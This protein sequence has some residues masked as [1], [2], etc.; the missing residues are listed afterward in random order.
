MANKTIGQLTEATSV[1]TTDLFLLEQTGTAK[2]LTGQTL[3]DQLAAALDGHGGIESIA[4][5][6]TSGLVDTYTITMTDGATFAFRV[7]NG[8]DGT[9]GTN[10]R[11]GTN[12]VSPTIAVSNITGGHRLTITDA[13]G[14]RTVNVMD[15]TNGTNGTN[16]TDG[17]DGTNGTNGTDGKDGTT[18]FP[19][20]SAEGVISW[21][22]DGGKSNP[23]SV[24][25]HGEDG[26]DGVDGVTFTPS[27]SAEGVISWTNDGGRVN[28]LSVNIK[29]AQGEQGDNWFV[30]IKWASVQPTSDAD[31]GDIPDAWMGVYGG[32]SATAPTHYT[33]YAWYE[34]KGAKGDNGDPITAIT[35]TSGDGSPGTDDTYTVYVNSTAVGTFIV[36]NGT[37]GIGT[38]NSINGIGVTS[39]TNNVVL[40]A[41]DVGAAAVPLHLQATVTSLPYTIS[42]REITSAM[43]VI[44]CTFGTPSAISSNVTWTTS[45]GSIVLSGT[46]S[47]S[48]TVDL[49][50]I[51][52]T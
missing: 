33:D 25:I 1:Q 6:S 13:N 2:K 17:K 35:R 14:T 30:Y 39:G 3:V 43:S 38:V 45:D 40:T 41:A 16:G 37:D 10:G 36:H 4:K 34:V 15:G 49:V 46:M 51:E 32:A 26:T 28:P 42:N 44:E 5:T 21:T 24:N 19:S 9:N 31:M 20:V 50:L 47:G 52:T 23:P 7:T 18:F 11:N 29:G 12:G 27:V 8:A 48:T 22:N